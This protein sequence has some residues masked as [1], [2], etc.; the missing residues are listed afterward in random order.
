MQ[1]GEG[2]FLVRSWADVAGKIADRVA[3]ANPAAVTLVVNGDA[4]TGGGIFRDQELVVQLPTTDPQVAYAAVKLR[5]LFDRMIAVAPADTTF[6]LFLTPGNHDRGKGRNDAMLQL[7]FALRVIGVPA[8]YH[9]RPCILDLAAPGTAPFFAWFDHGFGGSSYYP[10]S[11]A[12]IREV[13]KFLIEQADWRA[14]ADRI[15]RVIV[16]HTHWLAIGYHI[17]GEVFLDTAG[18]WTRQERIDLGLANRRVGAIVYVHDGATFTPST[19][20][21]AREAFRADRESAYLHED[22]AAD[23]VECIREFRTVLIDLGILSGR[24][25]RG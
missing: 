6:E 7:A 9:G 18:G 16:G 2:A 10:N 12:Q 8:T 22:N 1:F 23:Q 3:A 25:A 17:A 5:A 24:A 11:Y 20:T 13:W 21:P 15:R 19:A 4:V 14:N